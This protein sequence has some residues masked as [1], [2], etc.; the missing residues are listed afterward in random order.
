MLK[1]E[2]AKLA[3]AAAAMPVSLRWDAPLPDLAFLG[4]FLLMAL[5]HLASALLALGWITAAIC[6]GIVLS[7]LAAILLTRPEWRPLVGRLLLFGLVA[8]VIE[9][10]TDAAGEQIA[11]S[12]VYPADEPTL[13]QSPAYMPISWMVVLTLLGYLGWR[14]AGLLPLGWAVALG[15]LAGVLIIPFYEESAWYAGWWRYT[16]LPRLGHTPVYVFLFE[17]A[18][19]AILPLLARGLERLPLGWVAARGLILGVWMPLVAFVSWRL[20]GQG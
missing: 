10:A 8:G 6:D 13:W 17:G 18:I 1:S 5:C 20:L 16:T 15:G 9:L 14:L 2:K 19:V 4:L 12:L 3:P 11:R 7:Y